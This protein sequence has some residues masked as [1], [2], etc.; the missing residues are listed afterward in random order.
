MPVRTLIFAKAPSAGS[1]K[2]RLI[3]ALGAEGAARLAQQMLQ[4]TLNE[5]IAAG[6]GP[7]ELCVTPA[8]D[9][10]A[11]ANQP[12]PSSICCSD[13]GA[14]DLGERMARAAQR[15]LQA[16][17]SLLLIGTDCPALDAE[18]LQVAAQALQ[19]V[20][21]VI[22]PAAD[23]GYVLLGLKRFHPA[24]FTEMPWSS[25]Q[26]SRITLQRLQQLGW[27]VQAQSTLHD[28]DEPAD[29]RWLPVQWSSANELRTSDIS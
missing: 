6:I 23:G 10:P 15:T 19:R 28:I 25:N 7:V 17:E 24:L 16:G 1:A 11:W 22:T 20:D 5:A 12:L 4:H 13:Q 9:D 2:T 27:S 26:V 8:I 3:P 14:G 21:C 29:L 18:R